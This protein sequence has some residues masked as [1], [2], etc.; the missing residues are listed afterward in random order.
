M[1]KLLLP[2]TNILHM[3]EY[4]G[5]NISRDTILYGKYIK[6]LV[7]GHIVFG[8]AKGKRCINKSPMADVL[9]KVQLIGLIVP[10][11][12][13]LW[14]LLI[15]LAHI[16][17]HCCLTQWY[18]IQVRNIGSSLHPHPSITPQTLS[19]LTQT[20]HKILAFTS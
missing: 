1:W 3:Y 7:L 15:W 8:T 13:A 10:L 19:S 9:V 12:R 20:N 5:F 11:L 4:G 6:D 14:P 17:E 2:Y 18:N 16:L